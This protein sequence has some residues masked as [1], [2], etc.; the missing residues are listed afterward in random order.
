[1]AAVKHYIN[2][3]RPYFILGTVIGA[4]LELSKRNSLYLVSSDDDEFLIKRKLTK[5]AKK[6]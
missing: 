2:R 5:L 6:Q 1:M 3:Y 4:A